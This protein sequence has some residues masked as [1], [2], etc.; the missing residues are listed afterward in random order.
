MSLKKETWQPPWATRAS[1]LALAQYNVL[2]PCQ[3][4]DTVQ[5]PSTEGLP[6]CGQLCFE[7]IFSIGNTSSH[8]FY[9]QTLQPCQLFSTGEQLPA[10]FTSL[11]LRV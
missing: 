4:Q 2:P 7:S 11:F 6:H 1:A 8:H 9:C 3:G 10:A 5:I